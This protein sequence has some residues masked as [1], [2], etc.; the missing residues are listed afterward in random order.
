MAECDLLAG[1]AVRALGA[2]IPRRKIM[3]RAAK[4]GEAKDGE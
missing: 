3:R 2:G 1:S 4:D